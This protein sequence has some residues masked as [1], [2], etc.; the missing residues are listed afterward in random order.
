LFDPFFHPDASVL[1]ESYD[2]IAAS[3]VAEHLYDPAKEFARLRRLL[4][5]G[6][7]LGIMTERCSHETDF[8]SWYYRRDPTH[9][10]FYSRETLEWIRDKYAFKEL[11]IYSPRLAELLT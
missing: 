5:P 1:E 6:G 8:G 10:A 3:E 2:F 9:V 7:R 4:K 11:R